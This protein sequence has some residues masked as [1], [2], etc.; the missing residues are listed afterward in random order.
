MQDPGDVRA[1]AA[2]ATQATA[3]ACVHARQKQWQEL[4]RLPEDTVCTATIY[5]S[6]NMEACACDNPQWMCTMHN[7][8][9]RCMQ[10]VPICLRSE[11]W[12]R[13]QLVRVWGTSVSSFSDVNW[14]AHHLAVVTHCFVQ[15]AKDP[16]VGGTTMDQPI[17]NVSICIWMAAAL[18][19]MLHVAGMTPQF[20]KLVC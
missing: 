20:K 19:T 9:M 4:F 12:L 8:D 10:G 15:V 2:A 17:F 18:T 6:N 14:R 13:Q 11:I 16:S 5:C 1:F 3:I 7:T